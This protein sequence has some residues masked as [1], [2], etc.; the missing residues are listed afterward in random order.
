MLA[1]DLI[2]QIFALRAGGEEVD[3][4]TIMKMVDRI[5]WLGD[6]EVRVEEPRRYLPTSCGGC[7]YK[8]F[9]E[10]HC[11]DLCQ[12]CKYKKYGEENGIHYESEKQLEMPT[13][14]KE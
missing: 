14:E 11:D 1:D 9:C 4:E 6:E 2:D 3:R 10:E 7:R 12:Y 13:G 8:A 5:G